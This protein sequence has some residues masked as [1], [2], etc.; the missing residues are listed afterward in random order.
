MGA[1]LTGVPARAA[2]LAFGA[3]SFA[4]A[5]GVWKRSPAA[6][7]GLLLFQVFGLVNLFT[8][9]S[10]DMAEFTR[11]SGYAQDPKAVE[12][13]TRLFHSAG[14]Y[15]VLTAVW[16][17]LMWFLWSVRGQFRGEIFPGHRRGPGQNA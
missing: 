12:I 3:A 2:V 7:W 4:L 8:L 5:W 10:L 13:Q 11:A 14:F 17:A 6:W 9:R 1:M 15:G 16:I